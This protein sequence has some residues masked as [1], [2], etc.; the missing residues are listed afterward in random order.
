MDA[1]RDWT[2]LEQKKLDQI[3]EFTLS[4]VLRPLCWIAS[5]ESVEL[6]ELARIQRPPSEEAALSLAINP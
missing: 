5:Q 1:R 4:M 3:D 2:K 6:S